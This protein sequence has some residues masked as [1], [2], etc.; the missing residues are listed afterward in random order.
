MQRWETVMH[1]FD[2]LIIKL[3]SNKIKEI[4]LKATRKP[5][6]LFF[7]PAQWPVRLSMLPSHRG[8]WWFQ[9]LLIP[10]KQV[11]EASPIRE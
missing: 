9:F 2:S 7:S 8:S 1:F 10:C 3:S 5:P 11:S 6:H 4:I